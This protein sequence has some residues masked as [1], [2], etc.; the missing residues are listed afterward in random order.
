MVPAIWSQF[1][2]ET[3]HTAP[4]PSISQKA[5]G[6]GLCN[7]LWHPASRLGNARVCWREIDSCL[8]L[9]VH[10]TPQL[11]GRVPGLNTPH[12]TYQSNA[13]RDSGNA[14]HSYWEHMKFKKWQLWSC[15]TSAL[16]N[17]W[18]SNTIHWPWNLRQYIPVRARN[19]ETFVFCSTER[20]KGSWLGMLPG[21][22]FTHRL[23]SSRPRQKA[24]VLH[25]IL[26]NTSS[27]MKCLNFG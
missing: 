14:I 23:N 3:H 8:H 10:P 27:S 16:N 5:T 19:V 9:N 1:T 12:L 24:A 6:H 13:C 25:T 11:C 4:Y 2:P 17:I 22:Y 18:T 21:C 7:S 20:V 26:P 15:E